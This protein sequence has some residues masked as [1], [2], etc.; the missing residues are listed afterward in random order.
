MDLVWDL[1]KTAEANLEI[2]RKLEL[3]N[4]QVVEI[5]YAVSRKE[6]QIYVLGEMKSKIGYSEC[7]FIFEALKRGAR[8]VRVHNV[9]VM[10][11]L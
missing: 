1:E 11:E 6:L 8:M 4:S 7:S 3:L 5:L 2:T 10:K 9:K